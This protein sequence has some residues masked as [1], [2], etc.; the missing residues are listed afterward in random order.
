MKKNLFCIVLA[1]CFSSC[2]KSEQYFALF[3]D[4]PNLHGKIPV[5][6]GKQQIGFSKGPVKQ[7]NEGM[8]ILSI[9]IDVQYCSL[10][11]SNTHVIAEN[12]VLEVRLCPEEDRYPLNPGSS[13]KGFG[14]EWGYQA[15]L[16]SL[17]GSNFIQKVQLLF[18]RH[19]R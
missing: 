17:K 15:H 9:Q 13:V 11:Q 4:Y 1:I 19:P 10:I 5:Y 2:Q 16:L 8:Y 14:S 7:E 3:K 18:H 12:G 6:F